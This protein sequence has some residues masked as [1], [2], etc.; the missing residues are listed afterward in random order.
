MKHS[1]DAERRSPEGEGRGLSEE[2]AD[3]KTSAEIHNAEDYQQI[4]QPKNAICMWTG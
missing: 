4:F 2:E 1:A 3:E